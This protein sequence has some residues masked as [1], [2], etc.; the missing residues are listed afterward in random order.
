MS[1]HPIDAPVAAGDFIPSESQFAEPMFRG[2]DVIGKSYIRTVGSAA[3][4]PVEYSVIDGMA[5]FEGDIAL[6]TVEEMEAL[7]EAVE[8]GQADVEGVAITGARFRW[9][10]MTIPWDSHASLR[11][12]AQSAIA[13]WEQ[14]TN[15]RFP[16][17]T[18]ANAGSFPNWISFQP[19]DGCSSAVGM[20]GGR[21]TVSL[22]TGCG[23]GQAIHEIGHAV[24]LWHEQSRE[25]RDSHVTINWANIDPTKTGN[26]NQHVTDGDDIGG[27]DF[28][29][30]MHYGSFA[31]SNNGQPTIVTKHGEAIGQRSGLSFGDKLAVYTLYPHGWSPWF[32]LGNPAGGFQGDPATISRNSTVANIY[33]RG[34][35]NALWQR[36][37]FDNHWGDWGRHNDGAQI[38]SDP[39][40]GSMGPDHEHV[41]ARGLDGNVWQKFW[42][43]AHGWSGWFNL[44]APVGG[45]IGGP[46]TISRNGSVAN[47]Y[48][49][50]HDNALWQ[51]AWFD[52]HWGDWGRHNDGAQIA[53][54]PTLGSMGPDHEHVF[55]RGLDGN[56]WQKFWTKAHG[57]SGWFNLGMPPGGF[58]GGPATISRNHDVCN[59]YVRGNDN[60][61]WQLAYYGG[62]WHGWGR[63]NDGGVLASRPALGSMGPNHEHVF[64]K[65][66]DGQVWQK[67]WQA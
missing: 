21:Q 9:P 57:W 8:T 29:S 2:S 37:W 40:L 17:R 65:G 31:F 30:I 46:A 28:G 42:T 36:A 62:Q 6:G 55:A 59:V 13:H 50:G 19:T 5:I 49:R 58:N 38:A 47:I 39:A 52:N 41:F 44:G 16:E 25:D 48:V 1:D 20:Q 7:K 64:V 67:Y 23:V 24:G 61:L 34:A 54:D 51:R 66:T 56:V 27:Y 4:K 18:A 63:H 12:T 22:G 53:S 35:D 60:A 14:F 26:F 43:K 33:A 11:A 15:M 10:N 3:L 45:F 32:A